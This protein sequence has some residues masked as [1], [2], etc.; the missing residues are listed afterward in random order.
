MTSPE[1]RLATS[2]AR[3]LFAAAAVAALGGLS[4]ALGLGTGTMALPWRAGLAGGGLGAVW[5][6]GALWRASGRALVFSKAGLAEEGGRIIAP[7][8]AIEGVERGVFAFKPSGGFL[9]TLRA[10]MPAAWAPG[11][12]WRLGRHVGVGGTVTPAAARAMADMIA[13][14]LAGPRRG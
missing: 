4:V 5:L 12:W 3:R 9:V 10:P 7:I 13:T 1:F 6:A 2:S 11:L 8:E 14:E